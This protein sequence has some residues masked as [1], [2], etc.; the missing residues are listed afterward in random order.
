[1]SD[2]EKYEKLKQYLIDLEPYCNNCANNRS[3]D[4]CDECNRK[5]FNWEF[6]KSILSQFE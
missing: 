2:R 6:D 5:S 3:D 4:G 1:M